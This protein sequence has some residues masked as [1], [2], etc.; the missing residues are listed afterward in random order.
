MIAVARSAHNLAD[1]TCEEKGI[2][3]IDRQSFDELSSSLDALDELPDIK[4]GT[5]G[6]G[7]AKAEYI[8]STTSEDRNDIFYK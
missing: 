7:P 4:L 1:G 3:T 8:L 5:F 6:T 2:F